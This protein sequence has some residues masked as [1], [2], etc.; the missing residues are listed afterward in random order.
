M[1]VEVYETGYL[2]LTFTQRSGRKTSRG[3]QPMKKAGTYV[4]FG[5]LAEAPVP[6]AYNP[7]HDLESIWWLAAF[8][9]LNKDIVLLPESHGEKLEGGH[10]LHMRTPGGVIPIPAEDAIS[11]AN[12]VSTQARIMRT[13]FHHSTKRQPT[14]ANGLATLG[15]RLH[16]ALEAAGLVEALDSIR[17][18]LVTRYRDAE[19]ALSKTSPLIGPA[20]DLCDDIM[21]I[22]EDACGN[23]SMLSARVTVSD[24]ARAAALS[25]NVSRLQITGGVDQAMSGI[26]LMSI[27]EAPDVRQPQSETCN[28]DS[29]MDP[30]G[31][32]LPVTADLTPPVSVPAPPTTQR[33]TRNPLQVAPSTRRL[34]SQD[35]VATTAQ[36]AQPPPPP[37]VA[38]H[39]TTHT[40]NA[41][42]TND[43][44]PI[45]PPPGGP[46]SAIQQPTVQMAPGTSRDG[47]SSGAKSKK[48]VA[49]ARTATRKNLTKSTREESGQ[50]ATRPSGSGGGVKGRGGGKKGGRKK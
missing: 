36:P 24:L 44:P 50:A 35:D 47:P 4:K 45:L 27:A 21:D 37:V 48:P 16:P 11:V 34:R 9:T 26:A 49:S 3:V 38:A 13:L 15:L 39:P 12:R 2:F 17:I 20:P 43:P 42:A 8:F 14:F 6:W 41:G 1:A 32:N 30:T 18:R 31:V 28:T 10:T 22:L 5:S 29:L 19:A 25:R 40:T 7:I 46:G 23:L 33:R